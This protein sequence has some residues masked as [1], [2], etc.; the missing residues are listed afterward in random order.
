MVYLKARGNTGPWIAVLLLGRDQLTPS[1]GD[2][3]T[4]V[5]GDGMGTLEREGYLSE[6]MC[7]HKSFVL[8]DIV[9]FHA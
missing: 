4:L 8:D 2:T 9:I 3:G 1:V 5:G 7:K 6:E